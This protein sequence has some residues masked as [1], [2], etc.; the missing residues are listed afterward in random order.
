MALVQVT[1]VVPMDNPT[2]FTNPFTFEITFESIQDLE[3]DL[4]WKLIYVGS[5]EDSRYDQL[6]VEVAVGPVPAGVSK[7]VLHA[8]PPNPQLI[9]QN[10]VVGVT[11]ILLCCSYRGREFVRVGYYVNNE[12]PDRTNEDSSHL[13]GGGD[14]DLTDIDLKYVVRTILADKPRVTRFNIDWSPR[15]KFLHST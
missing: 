8:N 11:V 5:A 10:D 1:N 4:E 12:L 13:T 3:E 15:N 9:P 2:S 14:L 7:F 6:L